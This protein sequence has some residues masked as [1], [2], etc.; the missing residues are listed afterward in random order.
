MYTYSWGYFFQKC[1]TFHLST[2][3]GHLPFSP[4]Y[5]LSLVR[6]FWGFSLSTQNLTTQNNLVS[7]SNL[8][9]SLFIP[10]SMS[11]M[12]M[13]NKTGLS[14]GFCRTPLLTSWHPEKWPHSPTLYFLSCNQL[15]VHKKNLPFNP[16]E[17]LIF[18]FFFKGLWLGTMSNSFQRPSILCQWDPPCPCACWYSQRTP[19]DVWGKISLY[20]T[21]VDSLPADH[22][23]PCDWWF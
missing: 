12:K 23:C 6:S 10:I 16:M 20:N 5:S 14:T 11:L 21:H 22:I 1:I 4:H 8:E 15:S 19:A 13:L 7:S 2:L 3:E 17:M 9:I 18:L